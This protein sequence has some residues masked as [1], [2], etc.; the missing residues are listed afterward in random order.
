[1]KKVNP[2]PLSYTENS[3]TKKRGQ[4]YLGRKILVDNSG[5]K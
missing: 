4:G 5:R 3:G 1:M 2:W